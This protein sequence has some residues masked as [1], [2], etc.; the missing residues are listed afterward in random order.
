[1]ADLESA[2]VAPRNES[3]RQLDRDDL[4]HAL[5]QIAQMVG[6]AYAAADSMVGDDTRPEYFQLPWDDGERLAFALTDLMER[7]E[8][9]R[10]LMATRH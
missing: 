8:K 2:L 5:Y 1:M 4:D 6:I 10:G 3:S 7:V 9:L